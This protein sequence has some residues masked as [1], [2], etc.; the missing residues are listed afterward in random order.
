MKRILVEGG[1]YEGGNYYF[2][3]RDHLGNNRI[4]ANAAASVVQSTQ[5][6]PFG[7]PFAETSTAEQGKQPYKF[8]G[9]ELDQMHG[10]NF[11]D[12][13][14][15][16]MNGINFT[17]IDP[18][19]E[20][21][22]SLS[23]YVYCANNPLRFIDPTGMQ[24]GDFVD[25]KGKVIGDDGIDDQRTYVMKTNA[26]DES[27]KYIKENSGKPLSFKD[28]NNIA[29]QNSIEIECD[30]KVR[31]DMVDEVSK[32]NGKGGKKDANNRE[33]GG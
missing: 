33:Y 20:K 4:V 19:A 30:P 16:Y 3:I 12:V 8:G 17:T 13:S 31:Q 32:D 29:Y 26:S 9:K 23:P 7:M 5:Y 24:Y 1:Y 28:K 18:M 14:A 15:R 11:Y 27:V 6:Y 22:Y 2:Y 21:Y 10:L 25:A